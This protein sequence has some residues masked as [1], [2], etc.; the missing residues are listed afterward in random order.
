[1]VSLKI[2]A[3]TSFGEKT[4]IVQI[5]ID[6][7]HKNLYVRRSLILCRVEGHGGGIFRSS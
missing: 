6:Q 2:R 7:K 5:H 4:P 3:K 1:M